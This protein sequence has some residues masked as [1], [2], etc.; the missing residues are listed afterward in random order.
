MFERPDALR[1]AA[2]RSAQAP[3]PHPQ[4]RRRRKKRARGG[5]RPGRPG[6]G[7][8]ARRRRPDPGSPPTPSTPSAADRAVRLAE[9]LPR[10]RL[11]LGRRITPE[12]IRLLR[13]RPERLQ[14]GR[15]RAA[16]R[17]SDLAVQRRQGHRPQRAAHRRHRLLPGAPL[18]LWTTR[19]STSTTDGSGTAP[20]TGEPSV[21][22]SES[23]RALLHRALRRRPASERGGR[24]RRRGGRHLQRAASRA[25]LRERP[26]P[27]RSRAARPRPGRAATRG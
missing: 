27:R 2:R 19:A 14:A 26:H 21:K 9:N 3:G 1:A 18:A 17:D 25:N 5:D 4:P 13:T 6:L 20:H 22:I 11:R 23:R 7:C 16:P 12:G 10:R 15:R 24:R 8:C